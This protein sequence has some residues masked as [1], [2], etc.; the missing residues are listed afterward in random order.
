MASRLMQTRR[1]AKLGTPEY[2]KAEREPPASGGGQD[3]TG[4]AS[5]YGVRESVEF[6]REALA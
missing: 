6:V 2:V 1:P 3:E 4:F 5:I